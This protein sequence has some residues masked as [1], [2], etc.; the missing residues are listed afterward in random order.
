MLLTTSKR[1]AS[2]VSKEI[3]R[4][5]ENTFPR[6]RSRARRSLRIRRLLLVRSLDEAVEISNRFAPEH[7]NIPDDSLLKKVRHAGSVFIGPWE[8]RGRGR[9]RHRSE[10][11][12]AHRRRGKAAG[13]RFRWPTI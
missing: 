10:S 12:A 8:P 7:L 13:R 4:Q 2:A 3:G 5:L 6:Q 9:L 11:R 1:L